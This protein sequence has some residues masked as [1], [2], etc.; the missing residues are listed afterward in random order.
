MSSARSASESVCL[1]AP[2]TLPC[3][4]TV[5]LSAISR[6]SRS[7]WVMKTIA[8]PSSKRTHHPH[9]LIGLLRREHGGRFV[10]DQILGIVGQRF[11]NL[12]PA[13]RLPEDL[14]SG[15]SGSTSRP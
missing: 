9:Q 1:A 15:A 3:L 2:T 12:Y 13:G 11:Q 4:I 8:L 6:T 14:R 10:E 5:I 7:L